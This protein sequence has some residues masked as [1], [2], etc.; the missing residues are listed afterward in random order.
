VNE[1]LDET[2]YAQLDAQGPAVRRD[3]EGSGVL[4][5][6]AHSTAAAAAAASSAPA[7]ANADADAN[8]SGS[9]F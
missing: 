4:P 6:L 7:A 1:T 3:F 8:G 5:P 2:V 9:F